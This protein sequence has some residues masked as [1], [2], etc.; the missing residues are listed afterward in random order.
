MDATPDLPR[1]PRVPVF[2]MPTVV[3]ASVGLLVLIHLVRTLLPDV[4]DITLLIDLALVP[5]RWTA[6]LDPGR[7]DE[8]LRAA[9]AWPGSALEVEA[10]TAFANYLLAD[11]SA[12]PWTFA[13]YGLL[14][15]SWAHVI[16]NVLWLA[17]FGTPVARR[18]GTW[19]FVVIGLVSTVA[20]G[21][22]HVAI[23]PLSTLPLV[24]ASAGVSGLMA[25]AT[26]FVF[27]PAPQP[28]LQPGLLP[29]QR[30]VP[31]RLQTIPEL[32]RNRAAAIF[33][34]IWLVTNLL[35]G[36]AAV[37]LGVSDAGIAWD[38]HLG[39]F[40]AGFLLLPLLDR[41]RGS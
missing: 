27:H 35:F 36:L 39:G 37:P 6:A 31:A 11:P 34:A 4:W 19:R 12:M 15:G 20:G 26:R 29:W 10:R 8:I 9:A 5:A 24:G 22:L 32:L 16:L 7:A 40:F 2:N 17:A 18:C 28:G 23:D 41:Q 21:A 1:P 13:T 3:T 25:A 14:H 30:P 33:L 38:A